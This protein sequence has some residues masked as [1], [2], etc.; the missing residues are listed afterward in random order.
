MIIKHHPSLVAGLVGLVVDHVLHLLLL[1]LQQGA[2]EAQGLL[3][4]DQAGRDQRFAAG[5]HAVAAALLILGSVGVKDMSLDIA[6]ESHWVG[7]VV[8]DG[9]PELIGVLLDERESRVDL[10]QSLVAEGVCA[11]Q[12]WC[13]VAVGFGEVGQEGLGDAVITLICVLYRLGAVLVT[14]EDGDGVGD[15]GVGCEVLYEG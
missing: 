12:V 7:G 15:D 9:V 3:R 1:G 6:H 4:Q 14:L 11:G 13:D 2:E 10:R 5:H 8:V